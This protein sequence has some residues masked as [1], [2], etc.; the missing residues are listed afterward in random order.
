VYGQTDAE[1][2]ASLAARI[3]RKGFEA[4]QAKM[5]PALRVT[6]EATAED[7]AFADWRYAMFCSTEVDRHSR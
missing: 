6:D 4:A 5:C 7:K 2:V 3:D 1:A